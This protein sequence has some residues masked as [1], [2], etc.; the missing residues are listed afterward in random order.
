MSGARTEAS[1]T[2]VLRKGG[3]PSP[4]LGLRLEE[5]TSPH[6]T[7]KKGITSGSWATCSVTPQKQH[8]EYSQGLTSNKGSCQSFQRSL[9]VGR[10]DAE[11]HLQT[12]RCPIQYW[13]W[14]I[15]K[16]VWGGFPASCVMKNLVRGPE[17]NPRVASS[18]LGAHRLYL[19]YSW[20]PEK[21]R[22]L[23]A[24]CAPAEKPRLSL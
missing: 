5:T 6:Q 12:L 1:L 8:T 17:L 23:G 18:D 19:P 15:L 20:S 7:P 9:P 21:R 4:T 16:D 22:H 11:G 24:C 10:D 2:S 13:G 3:A 14:E